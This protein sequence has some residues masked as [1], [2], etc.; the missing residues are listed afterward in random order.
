MSTEDTNTI[1]DKKNNTNSETKQNKVIPFLIYYLGVTIGTIIISVFVIGSLGLYTTKVA[2][3]HILPDN[4][5]LA[6]FSDINRIIK[7]VPIDINV[8]KP[9]HD[10]FS[11]NNENTIS[12][13]INFNSQE[14]LASFKD[15]FLCTLKSKAKPDSGIFSNTALYYSKVYDEI[16][17]INFKIINTFF[18]YLSYLPES[19][20]ML[21]YGSIALPLF[22]IFLSVSYLWTFFY[23][24]INIPQFFRA[25]SESNEKKWEPT[26][27]ISF[28]RIIPFIFLW[29]NCLGALISSSISPIFFTL[30]A[31][32]APLTASGKVNNKNYNVLNLILDSFSYKSK[33]F[34]DLA[35]IGLLINAFNFFTL[36]IALAI[37]PAI[38]ILYIIGEYKV[39]N[40]EVNTNGFTKSIG[41]NQTKVTFNKNDVNYN[42]VPFNVC[43]IPEEQ[44]GGL[45]SG[46][47]QSGGLQSGGKKYKMN[48]KKKYNIRFV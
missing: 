29:V 17:A 4:S 46:G 21:I 44:S 37:L 11:F 15:S 22:F 14:Y 34:L 26:N 30:Y 28:F 5:A 48:G 13:K 36:D 32:I 24:I 18:Y 35:T 39:E 40:P 45:Q 10:F 31:F 38:I 41:I 16:I 42:A 1:D 47:Q 9:W 8:V 20:I 6:P 33:F 43:T 12:Q 19:V 2:Q 25:A 7:D 27:K 3:S 23:H